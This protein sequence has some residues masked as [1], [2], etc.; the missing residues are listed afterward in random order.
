LRDAYKQLDSK[1]ALL[2]KNHE[3]GSKFQLFKM[4]S[5]DISDFHKGLSGRIGDPHLDFLNVMEAEHCHTD[6]SMTP[7]KTRN[8]GIQTCSHNEWQIVVQNV[9]TDVD[10][11]SGRTIPDLA[12]V[13]ELRVVKDANLC[14][15]EVIAV[16]L[17]TGP[18]VRSLPCTCICMC[19]CVI[20][21]VLYTG[22]M[23]IYM[24]ICIHIY[25]CVCM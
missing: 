17:Y 18:M 21:V 6:E 13:L 20:A 15:A 19:V 25:V 23:V 22:P 12:K 3:A 7:F 9:K 1:A 10:M 4:S 14:R 2:D 24:Y 16:V 8:Y 5:G 11:R